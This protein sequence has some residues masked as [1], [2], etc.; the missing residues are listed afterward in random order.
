MTASMM[1]FADIEADSTAIWKA[2]KLLNLLAYSD[3]T[4]PRCF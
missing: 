1:A 3:R 2:Y 4:W